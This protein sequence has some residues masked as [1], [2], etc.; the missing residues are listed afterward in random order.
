MKAKKDL[1]SFKFFL[2]FVVIINILLII[3]NFLNETDI[4]LSLFI[5]LFLIFIVG[6]VIYCY[7]KEKKWNKLFYVD[8]ITEGFSYEKFKEEYE[9]DQD[10]KSII[11]IDINNFDLINKHYGYELINKILKKTYNCITSFLKDRGF[12]S[13]KLDNCFI[14]SLNTHKTYEIVSF[15]E[16]VDSTIKNSFDIDFGVSINCGVYKG[17]KTTLEDA[18]M[19][20][21]TALNDAKKNPNQ[22]YEFYE[23]DKLNIL[24]ENKILLD[25][26]EKALKEDKLDIYFQAKYD[27]KTKNIIGSE[28][29][30]RWKDDDGNFI[31]PSRFIPSAEATGLVT[32]IDSYVLNKVCAIIADLK[33][34][35]LKPGMVSINVSRNKLDEE[36]MV[37]EYSNVFK[38]YN[39]TKKEIELEITEGTVLSDDH[40]VH[41]VIK[42]LIQKNFCILIDDFGTGYSSI[43][44]L[45]NLQMKGIKIDRAFII[46][47]T[48]KGKE[49]LKYVVSLAKGLNLE[50]IAEGVEDEAQYNYL[51][52]LG[53]DEIQGYYFSKPMPLDEYR[54]LL[55]NQK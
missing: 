15:I 48:K 35:S 30:L 46:D 5:M 23:E 28:A 4:K 49:I 34:E 14:I 25:K 22:F 19:K 51:K 11:I 41:N 31:P 10:T 42:K 38:K 12:C 24:L 20:A 27:V 8:P 26:L 39:L 9:K 33:N 53:C 40:I 3:I 7:L 32:K 52:Q 16:K 44:M 18:E 54:E 29:L 50:T 55:K 37:E 47:E 2:L 21:M 43:S 6:V 45:K 13:R 17:A 36:N 1:I